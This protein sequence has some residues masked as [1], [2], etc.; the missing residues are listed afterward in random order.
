[1]FGTIAR[2]TIKPGTLPQ[3]QVLGQEMTSDNR[4]RQ[5]GHIATYMYQGSD[6]P[7]EIWMVVMFESREAY[8][9][10]ADNPEQ[11]EQFIQMAQFFAAPPE[12]HDGEV[13]WAA[14]SRL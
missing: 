9:Q 5:S 13:I 7:N 6:D 1:M 3:L 14:D 4:L 10:N 12:W 8:R 11:N 2:L